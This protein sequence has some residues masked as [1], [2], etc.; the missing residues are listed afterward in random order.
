MERFDRGLSFVVP[1]GGRV[2]ALDVGE[3]RIGVACSDPTLLLAS[4]VDIVE[5]KAGRA[6]ERIAALAAAHSAGIVVVG[7]PLNMDGSVGPQA[8]RVRRF[9]DEL[10][11]LLAGVPVCYWDERLSTVEAHAIRLQSGVGQ[12]KRRQ[13]VDAVSA[14][15]ILQGW[16]DARRS[17]TAAAGP[18]T[19]PS[20]MPNQE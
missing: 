16:L 6:A 5:R 8:G 10:A 3:A 20:A 2:L 4:T 13:P 12:K 7:L 15:V 17:A 11:P 14:A 9:V 18:G 1:P 19:K